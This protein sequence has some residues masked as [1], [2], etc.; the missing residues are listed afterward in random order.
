MRE[1]YIEE[2]FPRY[3]IFGE[4]RDGLWVDVSDGEGDVAQHVSRENAGRIITDRD[5]IVDA[6]VDL[7]TAFNEADHE[8]WQL[9]WYGDNVSKALG[10]AT[11]TAGAGARKVAI[12]PAA[13]FLNV[14]DFFTFSGHHSQIY[15]TTATANGLLM[16]EPPLAEE[17]VIGEEIAKYI[18]LDGLG[19]GIAFVETIR[20]LVPNTGSQRGKASAQ[21][22]AP[23]ASKPGRQE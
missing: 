20:P 6:L 4:S 9:A 8:A 15:V 14:G 12:A 19:I 17:V 5:K 11:A 3:F 18:R 13:P 1:K 16:F 7:A 2:R 21:K 22:T 23:L 10:R